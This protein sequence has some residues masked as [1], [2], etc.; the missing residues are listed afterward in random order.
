MLSEE[1]YDEGCLTACRANLKAALDVCGEIGMPEAFSP[2]FLAQLSLALDHDLLHCIRGAEGKDGNPFNEARMPCTEI[3][4]A[5][6]NMS[7]DS[8]TRH[9]ADCSNLDARIN[10][11]ITVRVGDASFLADA[12]FN[13]V[14]AGYP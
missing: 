4:H 12:F 8:A 9:G 5:N 2:V 11:P 1:C 7:A 14:E 10:E 13:T 3:D 6:G